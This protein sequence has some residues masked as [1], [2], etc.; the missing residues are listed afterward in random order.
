MIVFCARK[1]E[2]F[3]FFFFFARKREI[4]LLVFLLV[5]FLLVFLL[6][7]FV[8]IFLVFWGVFFFVFRALARN[9]FGFLFRST[10]SKAGNSRSA[11]LCRTCAALVPHCGRICGAAPSVLIGWPLPLGFGL[12]GRLLLERR[13]RVRV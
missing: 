2:S 12:D 6:V 11:H 10:P 5:F 7:F 8:G 4:F 3:F 13:G 9:I 1:R